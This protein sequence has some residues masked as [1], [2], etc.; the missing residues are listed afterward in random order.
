MIKCVECNRKVRWMSTDGKCR[1][2]YHF[3]L[4]HDKRFFKKKYGIVAYLKE[5][6]L[7]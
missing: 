7:V 6:I 2:D 1:C 4:N 5:L 3:W